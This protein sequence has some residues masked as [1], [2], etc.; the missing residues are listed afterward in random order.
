MTE[1]EHLLLCL[2]E[3]CD[4]VGQ[5]VMKALRFGL[6]EVQPGQPHSNAARITHELHD[7]ISVAAILSD[8]GVIPN[9]Y[10]INAVVEAKAQKIAKFMEIGRR[11]GVLVQA[12]TLTPGA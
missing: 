2:A 11:E 5:R 1:T 9:P 12:S 8:M 4:E 10:P 3:E 6:D 7:L